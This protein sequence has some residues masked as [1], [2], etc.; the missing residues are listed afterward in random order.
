[1]SAAIAA[2]GDDWVA[3]EQFIVTE[4][5]FSRRIVGAALAIIDAQR[6]I[7]GRWALSGAFIA[8]ATLMRGG[9]VF[10]VPSWV[11]FLLLQPRRLAHYADGH[12]RIASDSAL[13]EGTRVCARAGQDAADHIAVVTARSG[14]S[15][16]T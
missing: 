2:L 4:G 12:R 7:V 1:M 9:G 5:L 3:L 10:V 11:A 13:L 6:S 16:R 15:P 8:A 14:N